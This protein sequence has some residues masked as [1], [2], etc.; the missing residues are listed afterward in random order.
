MSTE[1]CDVPYGLKELIAAVLEWHF[2]LEAAAEA[3]GKT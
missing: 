3:A 2:L 1:E